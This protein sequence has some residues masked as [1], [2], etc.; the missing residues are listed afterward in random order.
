MQSEYRCGPQRGYL[1]KGESVYS[2]DTADSSGGTWIKIL[3][4]TSRAGRLSGEALARPQESLPGEPPRRGA[5]LEDSPGL[6]PVMD[7]TA[8]TQYLCS[9]DPPI[10]DNGASLKKFVLANIFDPDKDVVTCL[11]VIKTKKSAQSEAELMGIFDEPG[12]TEDVRVSVT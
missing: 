2:M 11:E 4:W 3:R 10:T 8:C 7:D 5:G 1:T 12:D 6:L 9:L